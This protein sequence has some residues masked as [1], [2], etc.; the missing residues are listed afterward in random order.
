MAQELPSVPNVL[1]GMVATQMEHT[2][3]NRDARRVQMASTPLQAQPIAPPVLL[4]NRVQG[5][6]T[7]P[8]ES[9]SPLAAK[10]AQVAAMVLLEQM[11]VSDAPWER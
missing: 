8:T 9:L 10:R 1:L 11:S 2:L 7:L 4:G 5:Q 3:R 6:E